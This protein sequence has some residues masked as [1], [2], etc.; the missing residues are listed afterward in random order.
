MRCLPPVPV[1]GGPRRVG[2]RGELGAGGGEPVH[3]HEAGVP[4]NR[5][6]GPRGTAGARQSDRLGRGGDP[7]RTPQGPSHPSPT[8]P[9]LGG[10]AAD[11]PGR[12]VLG[13]DGE[14]LCQ[15]TTDQDSE[16]RPVGTGGTDGRHRQNDQRQ[17]HPR[18]Q[19]PGRMRRRHAPPQQQCV[20]RAAQDAG[21]DLRPVPPVLGPPAPAVVVA[22]ELEVRGRIGVL[23]D[24]PGD[25]VHPG[26][27]STVEE[28]GR[29][30]AFVRAQCQHQDQRRGQGPG[31][32]AVAIGRDGPRHGR[33]PLPLLGAAPVDAGQARPRV[34]RQQPHDSAEPART[35]GAGAYDPADR[36]G[37][38]GGGLLRGLRTACP[39]AP[40]R[41]CDDR[42]G[43]SETARQND[44]DRTEEIVGHVPRTHEVR[45]LPEP[46]RQRQAS[47]RCERPPN[48]PSTRNTRR[49]SPDRAIPASSPSHLGGGILMSTA[50]Q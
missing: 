43:E 38:N 27:A 39:G 6:R 1:H 2:F 22:P 17:S 19:P 46:A 36:G 44:G 35:G 20:V 49:L 4:Q 32:R 25:L 8:P 7:R 11:L 21:H 42:D 14:Q 41:P 50:P 24:A 37:E 40:V 29:I 5:H 33:P 3:G 10:P 13:Q 16:G 18:H 34:Q 30:T 31:Q 9:P 45:V 28:F 47:R 15:R 48:R 23:Q 26:E 12:P